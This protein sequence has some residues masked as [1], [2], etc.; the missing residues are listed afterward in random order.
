MQPLSGVAA[1]LA[2]SVALVLLEGCSTSAPYGAR[3][4]EPGRAG[5]NGFSVRYP[6]D[7]MAVSEVLWNPARPMNGPT[8]TR[9]PHWYCRLK[10]GG[11]GA[12]WLWVESDRDRKNQKYAH[13]PDGPF[14]NASRM[15][16]GLER[17]VKFSWGPG[18]SFV[19]IYANGVT[20]LRANNRELTYVVSGR[21]RDGRWWVA[22]IFPIAHPKLPRDVDDPRARS[23]D[24]QD[25]EKDG[26]R[27]SRFSPESFDPPMRI[28]DDIIGSLTFPE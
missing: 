6:A 16:K 7:L 25:Y 9:P 15:F 19:T 12:G 13:G 21:T 22:G 28:Y 4:D 24:V 27:I 3:I 11:K 18:T 8:V 5:S 14:M 23:N 1:S 10:N 26:A 20:G 2:V 17:Q